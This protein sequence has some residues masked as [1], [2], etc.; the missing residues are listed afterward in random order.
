MS[1]SIIIILILSVIG[2]GF[3]ISKMK[4]MTGK[5]L[6]IDDM[7]A[8]EKLNKCG[9]ISFAVNNMTELRAVCARPELAAYHAK[10]SIFH[11]R[12]RSPEGWLS[13][14]AVNRLTMNRVDQF[15]QFVEEA[16][17]E[18]IK[19]GNKPTF[20]TDLFIRTEAVANEE[21]QIAVLK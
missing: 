19:N 4:Y 16:L 21:K 6:P 7:S 10:I 17:N 14:D 2:L 1:I 15:P 5:K 12:K 3:I 13:W 20:H 18:S 8:V 11:G 9:E